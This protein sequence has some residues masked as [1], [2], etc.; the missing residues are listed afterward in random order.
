MKHYC[1]IGVG[2]WAHDSSLDEVNDA[3]TKLFG[4]FSNKKSV[5]KAIKD[6]P[7]KMH[8]RGNFNYLLIEE[9]KLD[10]LE[11]GTKTIAYYKLNGTF[12]EVKPPKWAKESFIRELLTI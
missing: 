5:K 7:E 1:L 10:K 8:E 9:V 11:G 2:G 12:S 4:F 3:P 6:F